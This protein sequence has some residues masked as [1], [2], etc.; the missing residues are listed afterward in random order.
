MPRYYENKYPEVDQLVMVQVQS[1]EDMG[2]YVKLL[3]YDN[4][5]GMILLSE[6]SRRRIRSVQKLIR[7]GRNEVV[8]VM[9]VDPD[10]GYI[11]LSKRRV[12]AEEVVKCE[13]QYEKGKAVDSILTQVAKKNET[14]PEDLYEKIA[15][16]LHKQY[17]HSHDAFKLSI[18][19]PE[20]VFGPLNLSEGVL[21]DL[22]AT[23][24]RRLTPK[25][26][27]V[28]ADV[29]VKCFAYAGIEA[30]RRALQAGED[31][32]T[33][34]VKINVRLVAPPLYVMTTTS[35]DKTAAI[36]VMEKAVDIIGETIASEGGDMT[37]KM[38][39]KV[40]SETE[41]AELKALME[42]FE[43]ANMDVAGDDD[44]DEEE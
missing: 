11:D 8:V 20:A 12:S 42:Q 28:R 5:E 1:I 33:E 18:A 35:T 15:W 29:E 38:K 27:K 39:P 25:P 41:D 6:L 14:Q 4:I 40:V 37:V 19:E 10:K 43:Q 17:G 3:E 23:I 16:P 21:A 44:S 24:A 13:E 31:A 22:K 36:E 30:I 26:V 32:S 2:A 9:R 7:V 34:D